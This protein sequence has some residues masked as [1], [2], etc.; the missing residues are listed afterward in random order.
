MRYYRVGNR[1]PRETTNMT[2]SMPSRLA[3]ILRSHQ[4]ELLRDWLSLQVGALGRRANAASEPSLKADSKGCELLLGKLS[5]MLSKA[6]AAPI[7]R[8]RNGMRSATF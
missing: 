8:E 1:L 7:C 3:E 5:R 2:P 6:G 4:E